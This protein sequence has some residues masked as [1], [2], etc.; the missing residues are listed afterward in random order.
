[1]NACG[2]L[3]ANVGGDFI[4]L[5]TAHATRNASFSVAAL[6][7]RGAIS[8]GQDITVQ[9]ATFLNTPQVNAIRRSSNQ[10][11]YPGCTTGSLGTCTAVIESLAAD[12]SIQAGRD[13]FINAPTVHNIGGSIIAG[14]NVDIATNDFLN[15]DR[16]L[17]AK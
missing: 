9:A 12:A 16:E 3:L 7:N 13:I 10:E 11:L 14:R 15:Q 4:D 17:V 5:S 1:M 8:A 6:R 2:N